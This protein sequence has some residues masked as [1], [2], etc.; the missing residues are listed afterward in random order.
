MKSGELFKLIMLMLNTYY[1][2]Y[3]VLFYLF[4]VNKKEYLGVSWARYH[5]DNNW[6]QLN[7]FQ[8]KYAAVELFQTNYADVEYL[9]S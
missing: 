8:I 2:L 3:V 6:I 5:F 9:L 1:Q 7:Q 4:D